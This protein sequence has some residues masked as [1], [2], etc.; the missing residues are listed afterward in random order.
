MEANIRCHLFMHKHLVRS[1]IQ[2]KK[3]A[4]VTESVRNRRS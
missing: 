3:M 1:I 2:H 4:I